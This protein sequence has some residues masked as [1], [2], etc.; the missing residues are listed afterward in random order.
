[1]NVFNFGFLNRNHGVYITQGLQTRLRTLLLSVDNVRKCHEQMM[2]QMR[3]VDENDESAST[4]PAAAFDEAEWREFQFMRFKELA[5][6]HK[7]FQV[8]LRFCISVQGR[9]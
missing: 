6:V 8:R 7:R 1:M 2:T 9:I 4:A 3:G 5:N